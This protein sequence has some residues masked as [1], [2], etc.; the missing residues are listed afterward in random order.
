MLVVTYISY[1]IPATY[2]DLF[3]AGIIVHQNAK[4]CQRSPS[5]SS[6]AMNLNRKSGFNISHAIKST[7][8]QKGQRKMPS[9]E[10]EEQDKT[11]EG[12]EGTS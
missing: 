1:P 11:Q 4:M 2:T 6:P 10:G 3:R 7:W 8:K 12:A 5:N 9:K